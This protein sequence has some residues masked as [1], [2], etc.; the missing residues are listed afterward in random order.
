M[1][2]VVCRVHRPFDIDR[3]VEV[4]RITDAL[5]ALMALKKKTQAN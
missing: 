4:L 2:P 5:K 3:M 1:S